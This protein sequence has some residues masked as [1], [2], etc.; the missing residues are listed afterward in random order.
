[1]IRAREIMTTPVATA[2]PD[3]PLKDV[4]ARMA[5]NRV[6]GLPIIDGD[7]RLVGIV[8]ESDFIRKFGLSS[9]QRFFGPVHRARAE[10][11]AA[12]VTAADLMTREVITSSP[13]ASLRELARSMSDHHVN[14]IPIVDGEALKGIVTRADIVRVFARPD[15]AVA[16][17]IRWRLVHQLGIDGTRLTVETQNGVVTLSGEVESRS[18]AVLAARMAAAMEG[19]VNV[20]VRGLRY[21]HDDLPTERRVSGHNAGSTADDL[22]MYEPMW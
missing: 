22:L 20:D 12:A 15:R 6:S 9:Q 8:T 13:D 7:G 1:M 18:D 10:D 3:T 5:A 17:E 4:A 2:H 11:A 14:R 19:V 21:R 16:D